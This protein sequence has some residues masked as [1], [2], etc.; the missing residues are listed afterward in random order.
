MKNKQT[1]EKDLKEKAD[2]LREQA[3][4]RAVLLEREGRDSERE[5]ERD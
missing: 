4:L 5:Y 3:S 2:K 1:D